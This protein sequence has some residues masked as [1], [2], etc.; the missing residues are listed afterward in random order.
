MIVYRRHYYNNVI[1]CKMIKY[2]VNI[3][4]FQKNIVIRKKFFTR[5]NKKMF[6][7]SLKYNDIDLKNKRTL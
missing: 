1:K 2:Q 4:K 6:I 3:S 7:P 5:K